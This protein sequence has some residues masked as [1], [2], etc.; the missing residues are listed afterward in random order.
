MLFKK[1][2]CIYP[3]SFAI[4]IWSG[5]SLILTIALDV[6]I[7]STKIDLRTGFLM[8]ICLSSILTLNYYSQLNLQKSQSKMEISNRKSNFNNS[9]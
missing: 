7:F 8:T 1:A 5:I 4:V 9:R 6:Y 2:L 3:L